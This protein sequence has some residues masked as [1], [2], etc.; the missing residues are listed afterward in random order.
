[1]F[2]YTRPDVRNTFFGRVAETNNDSGTGPKPLVPT[3]TWLAKLDGLLGE[4]HP[5]DIECLMLR[6]GNWASGPDFGR[7]LCG[8]AS[9]SALAPVRPA[10]V[11]IFVACPIRIRPTSGP[12]ALVR[13]I[14]CKPMLPDEGSI[15]GTFDHIERE[16]Y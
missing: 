7:I 10:G 16:P 13:N 8:K 2:V 14:G 15:S 9:K 6:A 5:A 11:T 1:M 12:E 3:S 4:Q